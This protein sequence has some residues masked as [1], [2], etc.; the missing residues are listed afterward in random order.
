MAGAVLI[1]IAMFVIGPIL[2]FVVGALWSAVLGWLLV[3]DADAR[4]EGGAEAAA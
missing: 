2:L 4:A 3:D 1:V